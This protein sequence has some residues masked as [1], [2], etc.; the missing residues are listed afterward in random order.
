MDNIWFAS[1]NVNEYENDDKIFYFYKFSW[2]PIVQ[3][4]DILLYSWCETYIFY[5]TVLG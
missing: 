5:L 2:F 3:E 1:K 4:D